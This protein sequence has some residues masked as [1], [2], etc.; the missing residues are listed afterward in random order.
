MSE[1]EKFFCCGQI[2]CRVRRQRRE[3]KDGGVFYVPLF[4]FEKIYKDVAGKW[5]VT[6]FFTR[7]DIASLDAV[8]HMAYERVFCEEREDKEEEG[9]NG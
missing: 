5:S 3:R 8:L 1:N 2:R 4:V 9:G 7:E 6:S